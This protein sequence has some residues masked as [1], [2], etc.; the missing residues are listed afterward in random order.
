MAGQKAPGPDGLPAE[1]YRRY[2][3]VLLPE[4][5]GVLN[6]SAM[7]G[8]LP[9]SIME[10]TIVVIHKEGKDPLNIS[11][12]RPISLLSMD[13]KILAKVL[14]PRLT[15]VIQKLVHPDQSVLI[16]GRS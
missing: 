15:M 9:T 4:L 13:V 1:T 2:K 8:E 5:L 16:P 3:K 12:C 7:E 6:W 11:S 14:A 10:S